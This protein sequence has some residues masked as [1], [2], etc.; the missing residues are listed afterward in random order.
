M[1]AGYHDDDPRAPAARSALPSHDA[2]LALAIVRRQ[3]NRS[4]NILLSAVEPMA[5]REL[6][7]ECDNGISIAWTLGHLAC[8]HDLFGTWLGADGRQL[9]SDTHHIFNSLD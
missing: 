9:A 7:L 8:V 5:D 1:S 4:G 6:Y 3:M 2:R